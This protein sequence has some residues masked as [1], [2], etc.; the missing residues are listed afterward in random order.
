M[1]YQFTT[2]Q[3]I[4][5]QNQLMLDVWNYFYEI[6]NPKYFDLHYLSSMMKGHQLGDRKANL[7]IS[8]LIHRNDSKYNEWLFDIITKCNII[9]SDVE[10]ITRLIEIKNGFKICMFYAVHQTDIFKMCLENDVFI[11]NIQRDA[12][13]WKKLRL[14]INT[15]PM[16]LFFNRY[17]A[18]NYVFKDT[19]NMTAIVMK[20]LASD[21]FPDDLY[22]E[23]MLLLE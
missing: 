9:P 4:R 3:N 10:L 6:K 11:S 23:L 13:N 21:Y 18:N 5:I 22:I 12:N 15:M 20:Y 19:N 1:Y 2:M 7:I 16:Y 14:Q 8:K 17:S